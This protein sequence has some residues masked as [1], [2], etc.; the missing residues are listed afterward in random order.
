MC[1]ILCIYYENKQEYMY[2]RQNYFIHIEVFYTLRMDNYFRLNYLFKGN[3]GLHL[4]FRNIIN[5]TL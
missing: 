2:D 3:D 4:S 1:N 5:F